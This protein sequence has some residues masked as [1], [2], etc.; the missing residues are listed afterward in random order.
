MFH[1]SPMYI[2]NTKLKLDLKFIHIHNSNPTFKMQNVSTAS[3]RTCGLTHFIIA[4]V[5]VFLLLASDSLSFCSKQLEN[6]NMQ[7][8]KYSLDYIYIWVL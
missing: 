8:F 3:L 6:S 5:V 2:M 4:Y 1:F 7:L